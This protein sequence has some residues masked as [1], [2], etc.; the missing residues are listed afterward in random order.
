M[1]TQD[2]LVQ[3]HTAREDEVALYQLNVTNFQLAIDYIDSGSADD[4]EYLSEF[5]ADL[6]ERLAAEL[7]QKRRAEVMLVVLQSQLETS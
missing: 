4:Q 5:R 7:Q 2:L 3:A 6:V 1:D